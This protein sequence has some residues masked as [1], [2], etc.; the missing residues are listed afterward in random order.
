MVFE[1]DVSVVQ[2]RHG[3]LAS[4]LSV[5][6][7]GFGSTPETAK[8]S[9]AKSVEAWCAGLRRDGSL[10]AAME[11]RGKKIVGDAFRVEINETVS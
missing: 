1:L 5:K 11:R 2:V 4:S 6:L 9:L 10:E 8:K 3:Y 7:A